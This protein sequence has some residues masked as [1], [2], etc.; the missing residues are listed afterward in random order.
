MFG[1]D[2]VFRR[3]EV[4]E[5]YPEYLL[6]HIEDYRY[7]IMPPV[8]GIRRFYTLVSMKAR[9]FCRKAARKIRR[10]IKG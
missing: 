4:D 10:M 8:S 3:V 1:R 5:S 6:A 2:A 7:L 9:R